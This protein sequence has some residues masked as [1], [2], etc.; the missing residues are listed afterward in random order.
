[1]LE[2]TSRSHNRVTDFR[3]NHV[4]SPEPTATFHVLDFHAA[5][6]SAMLANKVFFQSALVNI[7][8]TVFRDCGQFLYEFRSFFLGFFRVGERL[9][10]KVMPIFFNA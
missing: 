7:N 6:S 9:F 8:T 10:F 5:L 1:M 3:R 4:R 2:V